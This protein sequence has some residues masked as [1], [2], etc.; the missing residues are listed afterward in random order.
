LAHSLRIQAIAE[1]VEN[2]T[3]VAFLN[4]SGCDTVQGYFY[5]PP[6]SAKSFVDFLESQPPRQYR[7]NA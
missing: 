1:G 5:S 4:Q 3:Q 2:S 7:A 6:L